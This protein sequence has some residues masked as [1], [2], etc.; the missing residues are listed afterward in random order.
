M[1]TRYKSAVRKPRGWSSSFLAATVGNLPDECRRACP[2]ARGACVHRC[3]PL[4]NT[5]FEHRSRETGPAASYHV[6]VRAEKSQYR[7]PHCRQNSPTT[8]EGVC[9]WVAPDFDQPTVSVTS[10]VKTCSTRSVAQKS[11]STCVDSH[12][13]LV[14]ADSKWPATITSTMPSVCVCMEYLTYY[15]NDT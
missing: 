4:R 10:V 1:P 14:Y 12:C 11:M 6:F 2:T 9:G 8:T 3:S 13:R 5:C 7:D 15:D